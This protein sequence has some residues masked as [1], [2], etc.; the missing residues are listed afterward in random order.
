MPKKGGGKKGGKK[1]K[2]GPEDWGARQVE[3]YV[4][5]EVRNSIW[6]SMRFTERLPMSA[7]VVRF[8]RCAFRTCQLMRPWC[9]SSLP[10]RLRH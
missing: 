4:T 7:P 6:Q 8:V 9:C 3:K 2:K 10:A 1:G 5:V